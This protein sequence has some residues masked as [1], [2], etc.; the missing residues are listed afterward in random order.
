[1]AK[2]DLLTALDRRQSETTD[3][4]TAPRAP[5]KAKRR[6]STPIKAA[7]PAPAWEEPARDLKPIDTH[8]ANVEERVEGA[9]YAYRPHNSVSAAGA[10]VDIGE[11]IDPLPPLP[12]PMLCLLPQKPGI[13]HAYWVLPVE[14]ERRN[15]MTLRL[16]RVTEQSVEVLDEIKIT[17]QQGSYYFHVPEALGSHETLL[18]VG[19]YRDG[20]FVGVL[21]RASIRLSS[22]HAS[23][24]TDRRWWISEDDFRRVYLHSGGSTGPTRRHSW[25]GL[26]SSANLLASSEQAPLMSSASTGH[27][28]LT[29]RANES[30][31]PPRSRERDGEKGSE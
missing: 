10:P 21:S 25:S 11:H 24:Y 17:A 5:T 9:K 4:R 28:D 3:R 2:D 29:N 19:Y 22:R 14:L 20:Q 7:A 31:P 13:L 27:S 6:T 8:F 23:M 18:Q 12:T 30:T 1:M 16:C 26:G 15:D